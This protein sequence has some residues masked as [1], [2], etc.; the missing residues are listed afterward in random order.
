MEQRSA[1]V[2]KNEKVSILKDSIFHLVIVVHIF[3]PRKSTLE[4]PCFSN[5]TVYI[6]FPGE[7]VKNTI[8][9]IL[10]ACMQPSWQLQKVN[11]QIKLTYNLAQNFSVWVFL[12]YFKYL[13]SWV[14]TKNV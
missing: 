6:I 3:F 2:S 10:L 8:L 5:A 1:I 12:H 14:I 7:I 4:Q 9:C 13:S 11:R